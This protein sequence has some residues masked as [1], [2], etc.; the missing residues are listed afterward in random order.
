MLKIY[1]TIQELIRSLVPVLG[2][3]QRHDRDL[4]LQMRRALASVPRNV[5]E[6][7]LVRGKNRFARY[8]TAAGSM[9]EVQSCV[10]TAVSFGYVKTFDERLIDKMGHII[11]VLVKNIH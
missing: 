9:R 7:S 5:S 10:E 3:I 11:A 2:E 1:D 4:A 6:G 8:A